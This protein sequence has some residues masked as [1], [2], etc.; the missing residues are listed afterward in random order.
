M[1]VAFI[2]I[3]LFFSVFGIFYFYYYTRSRERLAIIEKGLDPGLFKLPAHEKVKSNG[4]KNGSSIKLSLK[5]GMFLIGAGLGFAC[6]AIL[7]EIFPLMPEEIMV[8]IMIS[9]FFVFSGASLVLSYYLGRNLDKKD[10]D[11]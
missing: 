7:L 9:T 6:G 1:G 3:A 2:F 5:F 11:K 10:I 4:K 8:F